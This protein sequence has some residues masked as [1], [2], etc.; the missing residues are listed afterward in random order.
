VGHHLP[1][2]DQDTRTSASSL[3]EAEAAEGIETTMPFSRSRRVDT[4]G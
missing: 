3:I 1:G 2:A 4:Q